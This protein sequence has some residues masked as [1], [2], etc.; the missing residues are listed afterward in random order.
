VDELYDL[1]LDPTETIDLLQRQLTGEQQAAHDQLRAELEALIGPQSAPFC[2]ASDGALAACPCGNAGS[3]DTGC[4]ITQGTGG[5]RLALVGQVTSPVNRATLAGAGFGAGAT[6]AIVLRAGSQDDASPVVFGDGL[7]CVGVPLVRFA[8][9]LSSGGVSTHVIGHG[10]SATQGTSFYQLW[11]RNSPPV[12][13]DP[14]AAFA[15]SSGR[16]LSW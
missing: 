9:A 6:P 3:L 7:R 8:P 11:F 16:T 12:F 1:V 4:D 2:D 14:A 13:C 5:V 10:A 15:L